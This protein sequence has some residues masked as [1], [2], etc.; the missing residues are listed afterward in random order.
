MTWNPGDF[1]KPDPELSSEATREYILNE[2]YQYF[3]NPKNTSER[4]VRIRKIVPSID[5]KVLGQIIFDILHAYLVDSRSALR[6][7]LPDDIAPE[8]FDE[9]IGFVDEDTLPDSSTTIMTLWTA[10]EPSPELSSETETESDVWDLTIPV[11]IHVVM[12][13]LAVIA[14][15]LFGMNVYCIPSNVKYPMA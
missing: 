4:L 5:S 8:F 13:G 10:T 7:L 2:L 3:S 1:I 6:D 11:P 15:W 14:M 9:V 12:A